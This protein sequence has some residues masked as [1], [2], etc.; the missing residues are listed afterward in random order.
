[1]NEPKNL[2][3]Q[4]SLE[5]IT[6]G[7]A[8]LS[9]LARVKK[10]AAHGRGSAPAGTQLTGLNRLVRKNITQ[11]QASTNKKDTPERESQP[12]TCFKCGKSGDIAR[13]CPEHTARIARVIID[14]DEESF[15]E[16]GEDY[17]E[18]IDFK[19]DQNYI[20]SFETG[21]WLD[22]LSKPE[23]RMMVI[24]IRQPKRRRKEGLRDHSEGSLWS[25]LGA[26]TYG[27]IGHYLSE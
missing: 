3:S 12:I 9:L 7:L 14:T 2:V 6:K 18:S 23:R 8:N 19:D 13:K 10:A 27:V 26:T 5:V 22:A 1:M 17:N 4:L 16:D 25:L 15:Y 20:E 21:I 11:G 24:K